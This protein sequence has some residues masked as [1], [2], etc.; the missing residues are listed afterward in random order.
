MSAHKAADSHGQELPE[1]VASVANGQDDSEDLFPEEAFKEKPTDD[2]RI[3]PE[4]MTMT[5]REFW[6]YVWEAMTLKY[7]RD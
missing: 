3:T 2:L 7:L 6:G 5:S 1:V 4:T